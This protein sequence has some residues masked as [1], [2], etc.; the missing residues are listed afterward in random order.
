M[1]FSSNYKDEVFSIIFKVTFQEMINTNIFQ[2]MAFKGE[3]AV[4]LTDN[5][6]LG[7]K[8]VVN[9]RMQ[10][11]ITIIGFPVYIYFPLH[12]A[13]VTWNRYRAHKTR[14]LAFY[15]VQFPLV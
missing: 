9:C 8:L 15:D 2:E 12:L 10:N 1:G 13:Y 3:F 4:V 5:P 14:F 6:L 7:L 11:Y